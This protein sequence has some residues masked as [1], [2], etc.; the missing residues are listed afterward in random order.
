[1]F[2]WNILHLLFTDISEFGTL[3]TALFITIFLFTVTLQLFLLFKA[4][5]IVRFLPIIIAASLTFLA[6]IAMWAFLYLLK[7]F[8]VF[9]IIVVLSYFLVATLGAAFGNIIYLLYRVFLK[10]KVRK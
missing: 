7:S 6:E 10:Y 4:K 2:I 8:V 9:I 3:H 1:M 5:R